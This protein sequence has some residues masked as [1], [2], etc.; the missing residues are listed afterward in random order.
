MA[1]ARR[2]T[3]AKKSATLTIDGRKHVCKL[4]KTRNKDGSFSLGRCQL[5]TKVG[6]KANK[7]KSTKSRSTK[8]LRRSA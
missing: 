2:K 3:I 7:S 8:K 1:K 6:K 4:G 5:A